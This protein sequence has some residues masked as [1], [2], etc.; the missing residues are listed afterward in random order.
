MP[1]PTRCG[2]LF[3]Y[4]DPI[5]RCVLAADH[6]GLHHSPGAEQDAPEQDPAERRFKRGDITPDPVT[7]MA[8]ELER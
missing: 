8:K 3:P 7:S 5:R 6:D 1:D 4:T 2:Y